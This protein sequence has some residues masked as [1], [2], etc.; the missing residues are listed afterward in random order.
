MTISVKI[1]GISTRRG[2]E[3]AIE[4]GA[5]YVGFVFF[6]RSPRNVSLARAAKL[7]GH[8]E[9]RVKTVALTVNADDAAIEK[10]MAECQP[11]FLQ[12][13]GDESVERVANMRELS[14]ASIIKAIKVRTARDA[15]AARAYEAVADILLFDA[16]APSLALCPGGNGLSFD[17]TLLR[18]AP[19]RPNFM[20]SGGL[21]SA[22]VRMALRVSGAS[23]VDVSSGVETLP[24]VKSPRLIRQFVRNVRSFDL[25]RPLATAA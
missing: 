24:G 21:N 19:L 16:Q 17:W 14:G 4:A 13:H 1:C 23:A 20:V 5:N 6:P 18:K 8:A 7:A 15:G 9:G 3:A 12:L 2:L 22:N 25:A 10:I 11:Q